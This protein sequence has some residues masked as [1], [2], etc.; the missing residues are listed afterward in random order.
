VEKYTDS[1]KFDIYTV[2]NFALYPDAAKMKDQMVTEG[3]KDAFVAAFHN[4]VRIKVVD[5]LKLA[6]GK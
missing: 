1:K 5:A 2:G 6:G 3:I 4:G